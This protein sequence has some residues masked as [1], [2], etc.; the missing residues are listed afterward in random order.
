M[1]GSLGSHSPDESRIEENYEVASSITS[2]KCHREHEQ[3]TVQKRTNIRPKLTIKNR[4]AAIADEEELNIGVF[5]KN[6]E[7]QAMN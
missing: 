4:P 6:P 1:I 3:F 7:P 5:I 2:Q